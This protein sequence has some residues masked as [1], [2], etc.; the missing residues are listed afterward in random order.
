MDN[1]TEDEKYILVDALNDGLM[2]PLL[3]IMEES[4]IVRQEAVL[5]YNLEA[6]MDRKLIS[7]KSELEG[8]VKLK[9]SIERKLNLYKKSID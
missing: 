8:A 3:K 7:L 9:M 5:S 2:K 1:L 6:G 4:V